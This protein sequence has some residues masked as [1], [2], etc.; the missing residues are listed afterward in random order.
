MRV[1]RIAGLV[2]MLATSCSAQAQVIALT[3]ACESQGMKPYP[4]P[5]EQLGA[6]T[7]FLDNAKFPTAAGLICDNVFAGMGA[8]QETAVKSTVIGGTQ[9]GTTDKDGKFG[10]SFL[11]AILGAGNDAKI[12]SSISKGNKWELKTGELKA[13]GQTQLGLIRFKVNP[14]SCLK[15]I[16]RSLGKKK[17][18]GV[19]LLYQSA[20]SSELSYKVSASSGG[21]A[22]I[23]INLGELISINPSFTVKKSGN[24]EVTVS[25]KPVNV[26]YAW[27]KYKL[28]P[29]SVVGPGHFVLSGDLG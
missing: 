25:G 16:Q 6:G 8:A 27:K 28:S 15:E 23:G 1:M 17:K 13:V 19:F 5:N 9:S 20:Q 18:M 26:C 29:D 3:S 24:S 12:D 11:K 7:L 10:I 22:G 21:N 14:G 4:A 2:A